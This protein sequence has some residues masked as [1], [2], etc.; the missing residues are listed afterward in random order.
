MARWL[1]VLGGTMG[2]FFRKSIRVG[3]LRFN[4]SKSGIGVSAGVPGFRV[5]TGPRG[6]YVQMGAGG[7]YYRTTLRPTRSAGP[8]RTQPHQG[9]EPISPVVPDNTAGPSIDIE[10]AHVA[11]LVDSSS[12]DLLEE[13]RRKK[14][15]PRLLIPA[16]L[17]SLIVTW[18]GFANLAD[19]WPLVVLGLLILGCIYVHIRDVLAR[20]VV[21]FYDLDE[22]MARAYEGLQCPTGARW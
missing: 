6:N 16:A 13:M 12:A 1:K 4:L 19:A 22:T 9:Y 15:R 20:T 21:L 14:K 3:P 8:A 17:I 5:G 10:S 18:W 2:L 11:E 7:I